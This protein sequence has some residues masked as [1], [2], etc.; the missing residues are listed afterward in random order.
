MNQQGSE[1]A[2]TALADRLLIR[3]AM[4]EYLPEQ[5]LWNRHRGVQAADLGQRILDNYTEMDAVLA[6]M[7]DTEITRYY[8]DLTKMR[9]V[10]ESLKS[11]IDS[12]NTGKCG[13]IPLY[14]VGCRAIL[15]QFIS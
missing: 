5:V 11:G 14:M 15:M 7:E 1:I 13:T 8:L 3:R 10:L 4:A 6:D 2:I 12:D 9:D